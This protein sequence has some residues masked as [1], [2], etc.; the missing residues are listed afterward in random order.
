[1]HLS[2]DICELLVELIFFFHNKPS[3]P[4]TD[5]HNVTIFIQFFHEIIFRSRYFTATYNLE[6]AV[7]TALRQ[8][9]KVF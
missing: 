1:M 8:Y 5:T 9:V 4:A 7:P 6:G 3:I 2:F